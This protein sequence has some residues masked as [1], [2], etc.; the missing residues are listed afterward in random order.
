MH[1]QT[2]AVRA[3]LVRLAS[4]SKWPVELTMTKVSLI[5]LAAAGFRYTG[6]SDGIVCSYCNK[7]VRGWLRTC[8]SPLAEHSC[9]TNGAA[10]HADTAER[11]VRAPRATTRTGVETASRCRPTVGLLTEAEA[12]LRSGNVAARGSTAAD[13]D[14]DMSTRQLEAD[15]VRRATSSVAS[16]SLDRRGVDNVAQSTSGDVRD[17]AAA[18]SSKSTRVLL[19]KLQISVCCRLFLCCS[20]EQQVIII[21]LVHARHAS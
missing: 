1:C 8:R 3:E 9:A 17:S 14:S 4:F 19:F 7:V 18:N 13:R 10:Q 16:S 5:R 2:D 21:F 6:D 20:V 11:D 15:W 12:T